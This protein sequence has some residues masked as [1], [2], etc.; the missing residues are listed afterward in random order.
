MRKKND[1]EKKKQK[2]EWA[3][4]HLVVKSRYIVLYRDR[5]GLGAPGG[6]A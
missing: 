6:L 3:T 2:L 1:V 4:A 5:H